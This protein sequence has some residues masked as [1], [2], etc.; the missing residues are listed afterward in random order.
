MLYYDL[1]IIGGGPAGMAA[2]LEA[3]RCGI[4]SILLLERERELGGILQ[5]CIHNGFGLTYFHSDLTGPEY[6]ERF[7]RRIKKSGICWKTDTTVISMSRDKK[8]RAVNPVDGYMEI[9][10]GAVILATGCRERTREALNIS[11]T[12]PAGVLTAGA[13]QR[14]MNIN[15]YRIGK[16]VVILG[17]G[18]IG[19]IMARRLML[20][21]SQVLA[22]AEIQAESSGLR[23]NLVQCLQDFDIP[24]LLNHTVIS[25]AG[26]GRV[27]EVTLARVDGNL[28]PIPGTERVLECDT[29]LLSVGLIPENELAMQAGIQLLPATGGPAVDH[30][31]ATSVESI[32]AC[33]NALYIHDLADRVSRE[34]EKAGRFASRYLQ[35]L[36]GNK[37]REL[38]DGA[39]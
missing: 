19:L 9:I 35:S 31:L 38:R 36:Q 29:L 2:A 10:A 27:E 11:G 26:S 13:A 25:I 4:N 3:E 5:Q 1:V 23:R 14:C 21:G 37:E 28:L 8:I 6:A 16:R 17:S 32:F 22:V 39:F 33:G 30:N 20:E 34:G 7:I 18:D 15:G 12:H 24:L